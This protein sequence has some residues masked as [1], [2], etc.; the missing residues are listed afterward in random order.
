M[1]SYLYDSHVNKK[2]ILC[3]SL[4]LN[5]KDYHELQQMYIK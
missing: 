2:L 4:R 5:L 3:L 1:F